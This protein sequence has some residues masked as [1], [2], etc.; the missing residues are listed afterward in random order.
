[1]SENDVQGRKQTGDKRFAEARLRVL[2]VFVRQLAGGQGREQ[3]I[4]NER[5]E[6][7]GE[8]MKTRTK[9]RMTL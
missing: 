8:Q 7:N 2:A 1:M 4:P 5:K 6:R 9:R 3:I